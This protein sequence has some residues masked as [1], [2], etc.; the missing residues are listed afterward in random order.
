MEIM[1]KA[2]NLE[3]E[4]LEKYAGNSLSKEIRDAQL[5]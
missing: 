4:T 2:K 1:L 5:P 3:Y